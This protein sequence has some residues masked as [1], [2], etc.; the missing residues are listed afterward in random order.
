MASF[1]HNMFDEIEDM[2]RQMDR[3][4]GHFAGAKR[5]VYFYSPVTWQP[6]MDIY[7]TADDL[8]IVLDAAG[9]DR[10]SLEIS[11]ERNTLAIRGERQD[12]PQGVR[13]KYHMA[14]IAFG[15]FE[16]IIELPV[17]VNADQ[18]SASHKDGLLEIVLPKASDRLVKS[19][20]IKAT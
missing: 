19:V 20:K 14:E 5:P 16:R 15:Y 1:R 9:V 8:V 6:A 10:D 12:K 18:A 17:A 13:E 3:F 2:Q 11:L 7:E 4:L